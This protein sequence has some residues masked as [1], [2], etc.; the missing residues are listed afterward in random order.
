MRVDLKQQTTE[1]LTPFL[2]KLL[3]TGIL[4]R[5]LRTNRILDRAQIIFVDLRVWI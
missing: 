3:A 5:K 1:G 2:N 4:N